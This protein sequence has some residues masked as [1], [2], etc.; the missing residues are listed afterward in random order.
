VG[1]DTLMTCPESLKQTDAPAKSR[2]KS[3]T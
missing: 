1:R 2:V 3:S